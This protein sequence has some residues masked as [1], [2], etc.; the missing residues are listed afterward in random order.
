MPTASSA[1]IPPSTP[2]M[3]S[4]YSAMYIAVAPLERILFFFGS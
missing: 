3:S 4:T 2:A 1:N